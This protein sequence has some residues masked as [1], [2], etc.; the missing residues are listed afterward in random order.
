[1]ISPKS[2][3][4]EDNFSGLFL[5]TLDI[6]LTELLN[7]FYFIIDEGDGESLFHF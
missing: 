5:L 2:I 6:D 1:M 7:L 3:R 4:G